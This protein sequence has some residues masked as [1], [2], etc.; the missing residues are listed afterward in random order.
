MLLNASVNILKHIEKP[1]LEI[2]KQLYQNLH[3]THKLYD[4]NYYLN[5]GADN[6]LT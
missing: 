4:I 1:Y 3:G 6:E 5:V 2:Q